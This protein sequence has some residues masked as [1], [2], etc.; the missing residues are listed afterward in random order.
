M[1]QSKD[2]LEFITAHVQKQGFVSVKKLSE[3]CQVTEMTI[4]RDLKWLEQRR[5]I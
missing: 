4:R 2:R 1:M 3:L 5:R